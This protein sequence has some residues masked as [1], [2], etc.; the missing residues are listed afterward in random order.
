[1]GNNCVPS[2]G[3]RMLPRWKT[4]SFKCI[5]EQS[6]SSRD[7]PAVVVIS[8]DVQDLLSLDT[9]NTVE[10]PSADRL[11][12]SH[13]RLVACAGLGP[14]CYTTKRSGKDGMGAVCLTQR[15]YTRSI[16]KTNSI[17]TVITTKL[18]AS[19]VQG[20]VEA[21]RCGDPSAVCWNGRKRRGE[22]GEGN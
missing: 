14:F 11:Y 1:M 4:V 20:L 15:E 21:R 8:V 18:P 7:L 3:S 5:Q 12:I 6:Q 22:G 19:S 9:Q 2:R 10:A 16:L 17:S 13:H